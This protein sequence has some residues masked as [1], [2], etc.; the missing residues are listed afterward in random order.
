MITAAEMTSDAKLLTH[1]TPN[2]LNARTQFTRA[3]DADLSFYNPSLLGTRD[4]L[5]NSLIKETA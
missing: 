5:I 3:T 1:I 4:Y 2:I